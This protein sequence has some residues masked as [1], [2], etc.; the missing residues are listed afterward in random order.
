M[1]GTS[2]MEMVEPP[3]E[4]TV[5]PYFDGIDCVMGNGEYGRSDSLTGWTLAANK[6]LGNEFVCA[7]RSKG[8]KKV[9]TNKKIYIQVTP[10]R[11][12]CFSSSNW[13]SSINRK[14]KRKIEN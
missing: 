3:M 9:R 10:K 5:L 13:T 6:A 4:D 2:G 7:C 8:K 12:P 14:N 1:E 11:K